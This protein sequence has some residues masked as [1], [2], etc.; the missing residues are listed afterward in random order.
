MACYGTGQ[1]ICRCSFGLLR[2]CPICVCCSLCQTYICCH[3][4]GA[5]KC[6]PSLNKIHAL[7]PFLLLLAHSYATQDFNPPPP[8]TLAL[9]ALHALTVLSSE[10]PEFSLP[11]L[12]LDLEPLLS[13]LRGTAT[14][15]KAPSKSPRIE[16]QRY[17]SRVLALSVLL[18]LLASRSASHKKKE[19]LMLDDLKSQVNPLSLPVLLE[20]LVVFRGKLDTADEDDLE[21]ALVLLEC[22]SE[23]CSTLDGLHDE[24]DEWRGIVDEDQP[25]NGEAM[26]E[27]APE[28]PHGGEDGIDDSMME[29]MQ[30]VA[31]S[32]NNDPALPEST[33]KLVQQYD[34]PSNLLALALKDASA[35]ASAEGIIPTAQT[36]V[37]SL[38]SLT[39]ARLMVRQRALEALNNFLFTLARQHAT[40]IVPP[41]LLQHLWTNLLQLSVSLVSSPNDALKCSV[42]CLWALASLSFGA[43]E[44]GDKSSEPLFEVQEQET[45][46]LLQMLQSSATGM[47]DLIAEI[48]SRVAGALA[49]LGSRENV[50][51]AENEVRLF[52]KL[53]LTELTK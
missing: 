46:A 24:Q 18:N 43:D 16:N 17:L 30:R 9:S 45:A 51:L 40:T 3:S 10:N 23:V 28:E 47:N 39:Q 13:L 48:Q 5:P 41:P 25:E 37:L 31:G 49:V 19:K 38:D 12:N 34:L 53:Y 32:G 14:H 6:L 33:S 22:L 42:G 2:E 27:D 4:E 35:S 1:K 8:V 44:Q 7:P 21:D 11:M 50:P 15:K 29:D 36:D 26:D 20:G 52:L